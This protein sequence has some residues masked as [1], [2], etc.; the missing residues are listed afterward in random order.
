[1]KTINK[2]FSILLV[3]G[4]ALSLASCA[5]E[6]QG[7]MDTTGKTPLATPSGVTYESTMSAATIVWDAVDNAAQYYYEIRNASS[8]VTSKGFT[9]GTSVTV[10]GLKHTSTYTLT[11]KAIP[12]GSGV[13]TY[14]ASAPVEM[15]ITTQAKLVRNYD[16]QCTATVYWGDGQSLKSDA[17]FFGL[18]SGTGKYV[19]ES[20][21]GVEGFDLVFTVDDNNNIIPDKESAAYCG[22]TSDWGVRLYHGLGGTSYEYATLDNHDGYSVFA[23]TNNENG[24]TAYAWGYDPNYNWTYWQ[25]VYGDGKGNAKD[26]G[27]DEPVDEGPDPDLD[28]DWEATSEISLDGEAT[29][30]Y[31]TISYSAAAKA[32]TIASWYGVEGYDVVFTRDENGYWVIDTE[33]SSAYASSCP[34]DDSIGLLYGGEG[35]SKILWIYPSDLSSGLTGDDAAGEVHIDVYDVDGNKTAYSLAWPAIISNGDLD[36]DWS[37]T[38]TATFGGYSGPATISYVAETGTY[39]VSGWCGVEGYD[40][41]FTRQKTGEWIFDREASSAYSRD[42]S[43]G[44]IGIISGYEGAATAWIYESYSSMEGDDKAG[45]IATYGWSPDSKWTEYRLEWSDS[46]WSSECHIVCEGAGLDAKGTISYV[47]ETGVYTI[48][49]WFGEAGSDLS[50]TVSNGSVIVD[51]SCSAYWDEGTDRWNL[52]AGSGVASIMKDADSSTFKGGKSG[53]KLVLGEPGWFYAV[54]GWYNYY[55]TW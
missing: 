44:D 4:A 28:Y 52:H 38:G 8:Y 20:W 49:G 17:A 12:S 48:A 42:G 50:F 14:C 55:L 2:I 34:K 39:T 9:E 7:E 40:I 23:T 47:A 25:L 46:D 27:D 18:E 3:V 15:E 37:A 1:M 13:K 54:S 30:I 10:N 5:E 29:G 22:M 31:T 21:C 53:G 36:Y 43:Y 19:C 51:S 33:N 11:L 24:G 41:V 16:W 45:Y 26:E 32:Y 35:A 6:L